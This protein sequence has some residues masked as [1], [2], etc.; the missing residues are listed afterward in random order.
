MS[1]KQLLKRMTKEKL[2]DEKMVAKNDTLSQEEK[3]EW[4]KK[5]DMY[6]QKILVCHRIKSESPTPG[7]YNEETWKRLHE[8]DC[9]ASYYYAENFR[10][11]KCSPWS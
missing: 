9:Q 7:E 11:R 8:V 10:K 1:E 6:R 2:Q 4:L 3:D 5:R